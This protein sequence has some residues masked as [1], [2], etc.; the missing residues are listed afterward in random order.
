MARSQRRPWRRLL[1]PTGA[2]CR[3]AL[4]WL[5]ANGADLGEFLGE[6][7]GDAEIGAA[8]R[9]AMDETLGDDGTL[10]AAPAAAIASAL[11]GSSAHSR[12]QSAGADE[13]LRRIRADELSRAEVMGIDRLPRHLLGTLSGPKIADADAEMSDGRGC[14]V[15]A[16]AELISAIAED[17]TCLESLLDLGVISALIGPL[18]AETPPPRALRYGCEVISRAL[19]HRR[20]LQGREREVLALFVQALLALVRLVWLERRPDLPQ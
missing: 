8:L 1:Q 7:R 18:S 2:H 6:F 12:L 15:G 17:D 4:S 3:A 13:I 16:S 14:A 19:G 5:C 11:L 10:R 20:G 9:R